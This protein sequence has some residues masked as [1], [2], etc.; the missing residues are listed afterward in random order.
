VRAGIVSGFE[1]VQPGRKK[2]PI[3]LEDHLRGKAAPKSAADNGVYGESCENG[4]TS[5]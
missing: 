1:W 2:R 3:F 5:G 4:V